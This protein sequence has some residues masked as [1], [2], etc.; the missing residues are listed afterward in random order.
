MH[1]VVPHLFSRDAPLRLD[2]SHGI[3]LDTARMEQ[4]GHAGQ[5]R[6]LSVTAAAIYTG[7]QTVAAF[8][9]WVRRGIMPRPMP[10]TRRYDRRAIDLALDRLS[11]IASQSPEPSAYGQWKRQNEGAAQRS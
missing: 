4:M 3:V 6:G 9:A 1:P 5:P 2:M 11:Q 7:C 10:G 8:R